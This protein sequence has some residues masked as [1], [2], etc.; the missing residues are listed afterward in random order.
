MDAIRS[1]AS[2]RMFDSKSAYYADV[3]AAGCEIVG[4]D[5]GGFSGT[6]GYK[7]EGVEQEIKTA[8][9]QL[10]AGTAPPIE[11]SAPVVLGGW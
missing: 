11:P 9:A 8:I 1:M 2:G 10:E 7:G 5:A 3:K 6:P 4:D